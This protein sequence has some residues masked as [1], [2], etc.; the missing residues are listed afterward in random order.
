M[1]NFKDWLKNIEEGTQV[2]NRPTI[3]SVTDRSNLLG[4]SAYFGRPDTQL[5]ISFGIDNQA[6]ASLAAGVGSGI[7]GSLERSGAVVD[8][9]PHLLP[10]PPRKDIGFQQGSLPLQLPVEEGRYF[11]STTASASFWSVMQKVADPLSDKR[12]LKIDDTSAE[13]KFPIP[14]YE[15][16]NQMYFSKTFTRTL[17]H[18]MIYNQM[19]KSGLDKKYELSKAELEAEGVKDGVLTCV[20]SFKK[21]KVLPNADYEG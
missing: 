5:P 3:G 21:S 8:P 10:K 4:A 19:K 2:K 17:I 11:L 16:E 9:A 15:D 18:I 20:F 14:N 6:L 12:V 1:K 13:G 7:R